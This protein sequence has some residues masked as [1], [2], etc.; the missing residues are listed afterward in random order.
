MA[1]MNRLQAIA[2][3]ASVTLSMTLEAANTLPRLHSS[4]DGRFILTADGKPFFYLADTAWELFH[5]L[6]RQDAA[7]YLRVRAQQGYTAIQAVALAELNGI[8]DPNAYGKLPL[9]DR[10]PARPAITPGSKAE[11][12]AQYDYWDHVDY[13][14]NEANRNG[15][16]VGLLP[17]WGRWVVKNPRAPE[18]TIFTET[19]AQTY[20]EFLG[21]RYRDKGIIWILGGDRSADG[22]ENVWRAL[23]RGIAIGVSGREDYGPV[24][25]GFHPRGGGS[26]STWFHHDEWLDV[27]MQQTGHGLAET[28]Q[29]WKKIAA[30]YALT[31][32]KPVI[33]A[34]PLY[35]DHPLAFRSKQNGYS[36]D[37]HVRQR[38]YWELFSGSCGHTY[39]NHAVWQMY[40]P[41][42]KPVNG[43]LMYWDEAIH[44]PGANEMRYVRELIE[45]RPVLSRVPDQSLVADELEGADHITAT[46]GDGYAFIYD[47][48]GRPFTVNLGKL[49]GE[50]LKCWW[51]N[52]RS[53]DSIDAGEIENRGTHDFTAPSEGFGSDWVLILDD[54]SKRYKGPARSGP[55]VI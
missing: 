51:F 44:R 52:P 32:P 2:V 41:G 40:A 39:G 16:Y 27:N 12:P 7:E 5:R 31:P 29:S 18:E 35:E 34:E 43:P 46:R 4:T 19:N 6:N 25:M 22:V 38:A 30:D 9:I 42:R 3:L 20:G 55:P 45:S 48:Q 15:M 37:A 28:V 23:A 21:R 13:I 26:S 49:S 10:D 53:G 24:I 33:D 17:T 47:A 36:F 8:T 50:R 54:V 14:V 11:D 1:H